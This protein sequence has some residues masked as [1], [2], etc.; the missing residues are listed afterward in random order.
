[1]RCSRAVYRCVV[2]VCL[3]AVLLPL[4]G[5]VGTLANLINAGWGNLV[6]ARFTGL[7]ERRVAVVCVSQSSL[8]GATNAA[9]EIGKRIQS[10]LQQRVPEIQL[11][12][13]QQ[14][15]DWIDKHDWNQIDY[16]EVGQGVR[17]DLLVAVDLTSFSIHEGKTLYRGK[18]DVHVAVHDIAAGR[19]VYEDVPPQMVFPV[20]AGMYTTE[21]SEEEFHRQFVDV[22]ANRIARQ[23]YEYEVTEEFGRDPTELG[24]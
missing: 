16:R 4:V 14:I 9:A 18:A 3:A 6:P 12:E 7:E 13:Q 2:A 1:M 8:F 24:F 21:V 11:V 20:T 10:L 22:V 5:C 15:D 19:V 23:F 17:A